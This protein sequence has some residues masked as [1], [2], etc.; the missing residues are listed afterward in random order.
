MASSPFASTSVLRHY[1]RGA[2][3]LLAAIGAGVGAALG[4]GAAVLLLLVT[5]LAWRG[6]PTCW[7]LGL[8]Q[9]RERTDCADGACPPRG[10]RVGASGARRSPSA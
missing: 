9:T 2:V 7:A 6:C 3:G 8:A 5:V 1:A 10:K 4:A